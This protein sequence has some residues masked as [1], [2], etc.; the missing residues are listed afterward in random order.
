MAAGISVE[1]SSR[2]RLSGWDIRRQL[3]ADYTDCK[4]SA[5]RWWLKPGEGFAPEKHGIQ[6]PH[7]LAFK[8]LI[9]LP[10]CFRERLKFSSSLKT[11]G[12][13]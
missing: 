8:K 2:Q 5:F 13:D 6:E 11:K 7:N 1:V 9:P 10:P 4:A 12:L 3:W